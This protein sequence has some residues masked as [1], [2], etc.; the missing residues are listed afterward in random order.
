V[1]KPGRLELGGIGTRIGGGGI[2]TTKVT[3][4]KRPFE[5]K[6]KGPSIRIWFKI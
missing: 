6:R 4:K 1:D 2:V 5:Q 3:G